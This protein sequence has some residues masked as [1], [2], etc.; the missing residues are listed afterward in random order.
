MKKLLLAS[1]LLL[2]SGFIAF[3]QTAVNFT[4]NDCAGTSHTLFTELDAGKV[5]VVTFVMP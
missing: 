3:G 2:L 5:I 4:G 1:S